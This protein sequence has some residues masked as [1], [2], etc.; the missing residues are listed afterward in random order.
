MPIDP[1]NYAWLDNAGKVVP[2][3]PRMVVEARSLVG[4]H[5]APGAVDNPAILKWAGE[6]GLNHEYTADSVPWC[7]LFMALV[8][9]RAGKTPPAAP[10]WA[11]NWAKF[12]DPAGQPG[13]GDVL[14][15]I[16][17]GGGHVALYIAEDATTYHVIGGNQS[18]Q[19]C[20]TRIEKG[21][22]HSAR[23]PHYMNQPASVRPYIVTAQGGVSTNEA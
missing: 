17:E 11:L 9:K 5:E 13:L 23:R 2:P 21:R 8:A 19:V 10:L 18:D 20:F 22:L 14:T 1:K 16:R 12:G 15:F 4:V 3:L 6:V 7:G